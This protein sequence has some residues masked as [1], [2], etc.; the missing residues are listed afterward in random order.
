MNE[1]TTPDP[2]P[3]RDSVLEG[4][5]ARLRSQASPIPPSAVEAAALRGR[6]RRLGLLLG[7]AVAAIAVLGGA[8]VVQAVSGDDDGSGEVAGGATGQPP[9]QPAEVEDFLASLDSQPVD[10]TKVQLVSTVSTFDNCEALVGDLRRVGAQHVGSRGF[11]NSEFFPVGAAFAEEAGMSRTAAAMD[12]DHSGAAAGGGADKTTLG[13]NVQVSGV[14]ELDYVKASG[15]MIYDLDGKGNLRITDATT[16]EV[17]STIGLTAAGQ[18]GGDDADRSGFGGQT[19]V[20]ELLVRDG[21]VL[22][23]G[24]EVEVSD[25]VEGD[26]SAT[27]AFTTYLTATFVDA[28]DPASP[29]I[30]DR[31]RLEGS[32]VSARLV[33]DEIRLVTTSHMADLGFVMPTTP[34]SVAKALEQNRRSVAS[35]TAADWIP[36]WQ[37]SGEDPQPLVPCERV[38]VP[39]TFS[40]VAMTSMVAF[41]IDSGRFEPQATSILAPGTTL[42][43]GLEKVAISSEVWVDPVDRERLEFDDWQTAVHEFSFAEGAAPGYE[44]SGIVD[45]STIGQFAFGEIGDSLAVVTTEGTP[46]GQDPETAIDLT[47]LTVSGE[48]QLAETAKIDDLAD[49]Q[50]QVTAV[51]FVEGRVLISTGFFGRTVDV[52]D[53]TDPTDPRRAGSTNLPSGVG[54]FH[55]LPDHRALV[56]GSRSDSVGSGDDRRSRS[57]VQVNLLD[58]SDPDAPQVLSTWERPWSSDQVGH[59]HHA[60]TYWPDR[61]LAMWGVQ[62][63]EWTGFGEQ[64]PN[65]AV[66]LGTDGAVSEVAVPV[67]NKPN[68][69]PPP[70][71]TVEVTDPE[72]QQMVGRG[73]VVL[74]CDEGAA[75]EIEW[76]RYSCFRVDQGTVNRYVPE[77]ERDGV[78][79]LCSP[80]GQPNVSRV[81]V[82]SGTPI[83][84]TDQ[85]LEALDPETFEST[86][87]AHHPTGMGIYW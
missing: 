5:G 29:T 9:G 87:I 67:A 35:S 80:A 23:F 70:C 18:D 24:T 42:Y 49:G 64:N 32:M 27:R 84:L 73:G 52:I 1:P 83:L 53:V 13:T 17:V 79:F 82:V 65:R 11:G 41:P 68:E 39:D 57:W 34:N 28:T 7:G 51:R 2:L 21:K 78:F 75:T 61:Q 36:D 30:T 15:N 44:G 33:D 58:V 85:T 63:T 86:A 14:D 66:V 72:I 12:A 10:P 50:G 81:L 55:P 20:S 37:R 25:P 47:V 43:A 59:D 62:D 74:R 40:G 38:H 22:V 4:A 31:V 71:P 46:W 16:L 48:G 56:V 3:E 6:T 19:Q 76:P 60:F 45:G 26:P 69:V 54:Y 77:G 8:L